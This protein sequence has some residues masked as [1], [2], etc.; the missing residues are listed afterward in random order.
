MIL[1]ILTYSITGIFIALWSYAS[2]PKFRNL[3]YFR[4]ILRSQAIPKWIVSP[5]TILLPLT[6][7]GIIILLI[8]S[9]TR[10]FGMYLSLTMM[11][12]FTIYVAGIMYQAY[13][14]Y[15]CPCGG[16]FSHMG[17]RKHFKVNIALTVLALVG[18]ILLERL[19]H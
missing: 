19:P 3:R 5:L 9:T 18:V 16:L 4:A 15:P 6:E 14:R 8:N 13:D 2:F 11:L 12:I 10:L 1:T 7:I 17:W